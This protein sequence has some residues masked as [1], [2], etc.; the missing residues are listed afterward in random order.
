MD[1]CGG[2][3]IAKK[4]GVLIGLMSLIKECGMLV[5]KKNG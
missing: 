3:M 5:C 4:Q 1:W 2:K